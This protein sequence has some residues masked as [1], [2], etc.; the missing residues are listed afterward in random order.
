MRNPVLGLSMKPGLHQQVV[1]A[2]RRRG[3]S[4]AAF[5][6]MVLMDNFERAER[7]RKRRLNEEEEVI[8]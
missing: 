7:Q 8:G 2:A 5:V 4:S 6:R 1:D 3:I